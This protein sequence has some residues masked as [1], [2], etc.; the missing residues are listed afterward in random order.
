MRRENDGR[1]VD[2][3][4]YEAYPGM[5]EAKMAEIGQEIQQRWGLDRVA[6]A[7]RLGRCEVG[8]ASIVIAV[9]SPHRRGPRPRPATTRSTGSRR[10]CRSGSA[11]S[12]GTARSGSGCTPEAG[13]SKPTL[14]RIQGS[15]RPI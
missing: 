3:L 13:G 2:Y 7:H 12:G 4:E 11:R 5:A 14:I 15:L 9:A 8:E 10:S 1:E 6:I